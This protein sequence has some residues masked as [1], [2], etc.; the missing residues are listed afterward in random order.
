VPGVALMESAGRGVVDVIARHHDVPRMRVLCFCG[1]G[2]NG[3][4]GLA[5]ARHLANRGMDVRIHLALPAAAYR[6][7]SDATI[8][9]AIVKAMDLP[10]HEHTGLDRPAL[11]IDALLGTGLVR[12]LRDPF[13]GAVAAINDAG[14]PVLA[15]DVP[16][17]IDA[18]TGRVLG[19]AVRATVTATMVAPKLGFT[20]EDGP[21]HVGRVVMIDIGVP[22]SVV[23]RALG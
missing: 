7:G 1:P 8:N 19:V 21:A 17:G 10:V 6:D 14:C 16:S 2:N 15:V 18:N 9:L 12:D 3:G 13:R 20:L 22:A 5:T 23:E 11:V 4:D